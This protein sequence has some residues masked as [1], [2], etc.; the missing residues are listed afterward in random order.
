MK[1]C[2]NSR[3]RRRGGDGTYLP[4]LTARLEINLHVS[5]VVISE[6]NGE[7]KLDLLNRM[8]GADLERL[9]EF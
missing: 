1:H 2:I 6:M 8:V 5:W 4:S 9:A 3:L 7:G